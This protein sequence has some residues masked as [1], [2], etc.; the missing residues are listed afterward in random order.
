M[1][2][3]YAC[4]Q[5]IEQALAAL[6][7][8]GHLP[9]EGLPPVQIER[10]KDKSHGDFACNIALMLAKLAKKK[11]RDIADL[12]VQAL[13]T[14]DWLADVQVAGPGFINFTCTDGA[15]QTVVAD[16]LD[17]GAAY[18]QA[19][20]SSPKKI[21]VEY[22][23]AN[24]TGPLHVGHGRHAAFGASL[25][26]LLRAAGHDVH[27]EYYVNDA[28]RQ[29]NI[30]ATSVWLRYLQLETPPIPF[31][32]NGYQGDYI[33]DIAVQLKET[34]QDKFVVA[35]DELLKDLPPDVADGGD[36]EIY[37]DAVIARAQQ[38]LGDNYDV[39]HAFGLGKILDDIRQD[40]SEFSVEYDEWMSEKSLVDKGGAEDA[41]AKLKEM[42]YTFERD[43]A[44]WFNSIHFGD[45]EDRVLVRANGQHTYFATDIANHLHK[46]E[47]GFDLV[48]DIFGADHHGYVARVQAALLAFGHAKEDYHTELVQFAILYRGKERLQMSTR[49]GQ[50][51]T[52]RQLRDEVGNDATR[53]FYVMRKP[54]QHLDFD[55]ELAK[56]KSNENPVYYIQYA[57]A[58][59]MS[60]F[61]QLDEKSLTFDQEQGLANV[62]LLT[63]EA[64]KDIMRELAQYPDLILQAANVYEPHQI[65][66]YCRQLANL[67]HAYYNG[68]QFIVD[69]AAHRNARLSLILAVKHVLKNGLT[70]L[71]VNAPD[72]M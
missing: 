16:V 1:I 50:F 26:N 21:H 33:Q 11:P 15:W 46:Y 48:V 43:G 51:I 41:I 58:R 6:V 38:L 7:A 31:P 55:L 72:K 66:N 20:Q 62:A 61:R 29:M 49:S 39:V 45:D 10:T 8:E 71:G 69:D 24:P 34:H 13:P 23:S 4:Q 18:G 53:F 22:V 59:I 35:A 57:Y 5:L 37:I 30:L 17:K 42:G 60:V 65:A 12:M 2:M 25:V 32:A 40:L 36:K 47:R 28:G 54:S 9:A 68:E 27:G 70:L 63:C 56:S 14:A 44:L 64:E 52:L 67:F 3:K 19:Q